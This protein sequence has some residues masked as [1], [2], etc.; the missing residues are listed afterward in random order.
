LLVPE[1]TQL[2]KQLLL[3]PENKELGNTV[4]L[5]LTLL[6][7]TLRGSSW[8]AAATECLELSYARLDSWDHG[9]QAGMAIM[10]WQGGYSVR[11]L[12]T[13]SQT[14]LIIGW[15]DSLFWHTQRIPWL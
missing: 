15:K 11:F 4:V 2:S 14:L 3:G 7:Q 10:V 13:L 12:P 5:L 1:I 6:L 8:P 9:L